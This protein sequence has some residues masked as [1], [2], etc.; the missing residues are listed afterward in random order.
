MRLWHQSLLPL[1]PGRQL[2]GQ[3]RE[4]CALRGNAWGRPHKTVDYVFLYDRQR[5]YDFHVLVM[6]E[7]LRRGYT[8]RNAQWW[9]HNYRGQNCRP[10]ET[11]RIERQYASCVYEEHD[12]DYLEECMENLKRKGV[13]LP[14]PEY[15]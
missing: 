7:M 14:R 1:L 5:L 6:E 15:F 13:L 3:H 8:V 2:L 4:V 10:D 11:D 12:P 9:R